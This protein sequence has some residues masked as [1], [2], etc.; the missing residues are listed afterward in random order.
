[1]EVSKEL[2]NKRLLKTLEMVKANPDHWDQKHWH[3]GTSHCFAGFANLLQFE[4]PAETH[5]DELED[6]NPRLDEWSVG[7]ATQW[8]GLT[9]YEARLLFSSTNR[10]EDLERII[11][12]IIAS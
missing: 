9:D 10:L 2:R 4:L 12:Q 11:S 1:M 6:I 8:L 7:S 5:E 3:C